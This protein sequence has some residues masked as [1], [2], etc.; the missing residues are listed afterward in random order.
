MRWHC[1]PLLLWLQSTL[2]SWEQ[3]DHCMWQSTVIKITHT[4]WGCCCCC[5][6][7]CY[8]YCCCCYGYYC[9]C[10]F[11]CYR[12]C[13][14][15]SCG[16]LDTVS[17]AAT[18]FAVAATDTIAASTAAAGLLLLLRLSLLLTIRCTGS[19]G[20]KAWRAEDSWSL[21]RWHPQTSRPTGNTLRCTTSM[22]TV[23]SA[24]Q[25][26]GKCPKS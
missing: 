20:L 3:S 21:T 22:V 14:C 8:G 10:C 26:C 18:D 25:N 2:W 13:C 6:C 16:Y 7:S 4:C 1:W 23:S 15:C 24:P 17:A 19:D 9:C 11:C 12:Y 5:C